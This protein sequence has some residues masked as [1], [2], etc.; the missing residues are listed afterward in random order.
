MKGQPGRCPFQIEGE[1]DAKT[2]DLVLLAVASG[3]LAGFAWFE[4]H[5]VFGWVFFSL[6]LCAIFGAAER[7]W[8]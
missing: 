4:D 5:T 8:R 1:M 7:H 6:G 2:R 3:I